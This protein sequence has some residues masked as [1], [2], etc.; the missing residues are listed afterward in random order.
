MTGAS[1]SGGGTVITT[2]MSGSEYGAFVNAENEVSGVL[3]VLPVAAYHASPLTVGNN[4]FIEFQCDVNG[5]LKTFVSGSYGGFVQPDSPVSG[6]FNVL[7]VANY[8]TASPTLTN[9]QFVGLQ[10]DVNGNLKTFQPISEDSTN[11]ITATTH[12]PLAVSTYCA[13]LFTNYG[14]NVTLNVKAS[15]GNV[16]AV[17]CSN[18]SGATRY[19]QLHN[20]ATTPAGGAGPLLS[21]LVPMNSE[22]GI[23]EDIFGQEGV[24]FTT[25][26]AFAFSTTEDTYSAGS[27]SEQKTFIRYK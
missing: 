26:I 10:A 15:A 9:N 25:G 16:F 21:F 23:G 2:I 19:V 7:P 6:V 8:R 17:V 22:V 5:N 14:A 1:F 20:T 18:R 24:N 13:S 11:G 4:Q 12:K 27:A 3:D